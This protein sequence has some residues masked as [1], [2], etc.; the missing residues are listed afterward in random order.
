MDSVEGQL[1]EVPLQVHC[2]DMFPRGKAGQGVEEGVF[3]NL[4]VE[5]VVAFATVELYPVGVGVEADICLLEGA[6]E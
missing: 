2:V 1:Q 3:S 5:E 6:L 4:V